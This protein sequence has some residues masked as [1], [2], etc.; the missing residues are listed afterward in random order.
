MGE[1]NENDASLK[2]DELKTHENMVK[3][4]RLIQI[5]RKTEQLGVTLLARNSIPPLQ[6]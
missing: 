4:S 6:S 5:F 3:H 1:K 2:G